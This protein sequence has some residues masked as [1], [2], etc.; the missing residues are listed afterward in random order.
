MSSRLSSALTDFAHG[1]WPGDRDTDPRMDPRQMEPHGF[2]LQEMEPPLH[3]SELDRFERT[4]SLIARWIP[5]AFARFLLFFFVGVGTTLAWQ[6][7]GNAARRVVAN[8]SPGL[9][10]LAPPAPAAASPAVAASSAATPATASPDQVAALS[11]SLA[12]VRQSVDK[13]AAD[14][15]KLQAAKQDPQ[16]ARTQASSVSSPQVSTPPAR[17][18][19]ATAQ[20]QPV[21]TR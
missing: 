12:A 14:I 11:R 20:V 3:P 5:V 2:D 13:L 6:H 4:R 16:P 8:L 7:Y 9:G 18:P 15:G 19:A 10:W 21:Q 1:R 17:R